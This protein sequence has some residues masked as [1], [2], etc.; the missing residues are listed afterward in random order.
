MDHDQL[1]RD[2][3]AGD[4]DAFT[5]LVRRYQ[6]MA[7]GYAWSR[8]GDF[9]LAE[10]LAQQAFIAAWRS[11][12]ALNDPARFGGWLRRIVQFECAHFLRDRPAATFP[13]DD[14]R[15]AIAN[16]DP[17]HD[18]ERREGF[19]RALAAINHLPQAEREVTI[20]FYLHDRSQRQVAAFLDLPVTTVNNRLRNARKRLR[21]GD[22]ITM[23]RQALNT[24]PL[25]GDF[26]DRIG[27]V[28][29][30]NGPIVDARF[31]PGE[32]PAVLNQVAISGANGGPALT[33]LVAQYLSDDLVRCIVTNE[34]AS[35]P[36]AKLA[37]R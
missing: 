10:D 33:A 5:E 12:P 23:T 1:V 15:Q 29:R 25:P 4:A 16:D 2:A 34:P 6:A 18:A 30:A 32:R 7:F 26:A 3:R 31:T 37:E 28:V 27:Q 13:L 17:T 35:E 24:H 36:T 20:L 11:L 21:E 19:D 9:H 22:L 14:A 8:I